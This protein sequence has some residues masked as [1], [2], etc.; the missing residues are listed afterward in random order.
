MHRVKPFLSSL[1]RPVAFAHRGG[2]RAYP[3]N[4]LYAFEKALNLHG[5]H[6][7]ELDVHSTKDGVLVVAHDDTVDRCTDAKGP[8]AGFT[9]RELKA[10]N[11]A[12][13]FPE[14]GRVEV[15]TLDEVLTAFPKARLNIEL[16]HEGPE[17]QFIRALEPHAARVCVGSEHDAVAARLAELAPDM[18]RFYPAQAALQVAMGVW[19]AGPLEADP[20]YDV[21]EVPYEFGGEV[22]ATKKFFDA[23]AK[24]GVPVFV[25]VVDDENVMR[26]LITDGAAGVMTDLPAVLQKVV[27]G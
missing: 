23:T 8:I 20:R 12:A 7:L 13:K 18:C 15:P 21:L 27:G 17:A 16:K 19:G 5:M 11:A 9:L 26:S 25:W 2:A 22:V 6:V 10:L 24:L 3:E 1:P 14:A 4:T